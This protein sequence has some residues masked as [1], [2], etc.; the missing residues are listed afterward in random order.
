[1]TTKDFKLI[2]NV[3]KKF[4]FETDRVSESVRL[5]QK[6]A[7]EFA[8]DLAQINERFDRSKFL[9]ACKSWSA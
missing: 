3:I 5:R 9:Q 8:F 2:A 6:L 4:N 7:E 1:M